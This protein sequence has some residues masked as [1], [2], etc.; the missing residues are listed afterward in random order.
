[1]VRR[2][3]AKV[4]GKMDI[5]VP[6]STAR[7]FEPRADCA[8]FHVKAADQYS[9]AGNDRAALA[10]FR[11]AGDDFDAALA[12]TTPGP[13]H[14]HTYPD[15]IDLLFDYAVAHSQRADVEQGR[16]AKIAELTEAIRMFTLRA[17]AQR[18][19]NYCGAGRS[20]IWPKSNMKTSP[21]R[22]T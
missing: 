9:R 1:M 20:P 8:S 19:R 7:H 16:L 3:G 6:I 13:I 11:A 10:E 12:R 2:A 17:I 5:L 18:I 21:R 4:N 14:D 22:A 15:R